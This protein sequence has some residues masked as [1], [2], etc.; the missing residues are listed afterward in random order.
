MKDLD[1]DLR[2]MLPGSIEL[3]RT[4]NV[5]YNWAFDSGIP[6]GYRLLESV[7]VYEFEGT[8]VVTADPDEVYPGVDDEVDEH[9]HNCDAMGCGQEHVMLR[10]R[11]VT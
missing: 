9:P 8:I 11:L 1:L 4:D 7:R 6:K 5:P 2:D 3:V 10:A